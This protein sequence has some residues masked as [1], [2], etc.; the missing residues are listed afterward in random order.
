MVNSLNVPEQKT[1]MKQLASRALLN[2]IVAFNE[3]II[4]F[5]ILSEVRLSPLGTVATL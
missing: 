5:I 3:I 1:S 2:E 4:F